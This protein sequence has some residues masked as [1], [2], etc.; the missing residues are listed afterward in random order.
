MTPQAFAADLATIPA[1]D[2]LTVRICSGGG[3]VWAAQAIGAML[4]N[5]LGTVTAQIE[6]ICASAATIV[7][8]HCKVV[9]AAE[10]ATYMIHPIKV[11][12]NGFVDMEGLKQLMDALTV[13]RTNVLNQYAKK[14]GHTV[15]EVAA[16]MDATSWWTAAEAKENGFIDEITE[17]NQTA[18]IEN[19]NGALFVNSIAVPGTFDDAPEFVRNRAVVAPATTEGFVNNTDPA[20][21]PDK[22]DGGN[23]ME[24]K[25]ADELRNGCPDLVKEIVDE[26]HAEAQKQERDRLAAID[27]IADGLP[28]VVAEQPWAK[29]LSAVYGELQGRMLEY[30]ATGMTFSDV[31]NCSEGMLDQMAIYLKIEWYDSAAD[32][33][34][35]RKLVR[36]AIEIQRYA[37]TVKAV[38][39]QVETI[40][41]KAR[42]EE[43]FSYGGTPGFWK[44]YVDITDDQETY[45]TAA[46]M[47]KLLG[48]TKRCTAHLEHIIYTIEPHERSPA[49]IAA[50]P[51]GMA[52][53]C[54]VK[55]PGRIKPRE[56]GAKAYVAGAVG[57]SKMQ[58]AVALPGAVEAK[59]VKARAFTAGTV[60]RSHTAI[61]IV[62]GGQTT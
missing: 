51:C 58:V 61:N 23:D 46:E 35:K 25:N 24:F 56:V 5:R 31:D 57:R 6:G 45:H 36:T 13:M 20:G 42:I 49:Y 30:L 11:N 40:Y 1:M 22:N 28:R 4:E 8:S 59:A 9:K 14:T 12:P 10:D 50:V 3:D 37:G 27:E 44:L 16:W 18:K 47:E 7:A 43:W 34:T 41:K 39:E 53:S 2:D 21:K 52:T 55:V 26:A 62:I 48:Y 17:S 15:E 33:E 54:T 19:R 32:I 60:E 38:R 29:V